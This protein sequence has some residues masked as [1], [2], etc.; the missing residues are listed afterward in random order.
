MMMPIDDPGP[1]ADT[2]RTWALDEDLKRHAMSIPA[3]A[4]AARRVARRYIAG[5]SVEDALDYL[6]T[7]D[8]RG[9]AY[10]VEC[11]GESVRDAETAERETEAFLR[12]IPQVDAAGYSPTISF[13]LSHVGSLVDPGL[14]LGNAMLIAEAADAAGT[15]L[16]ISAEGSDRTDLVLDLFEQLSDVYPATGITLQARL[17]RSSGDLERVLDRPG[18]VR[19]VK[20]AFLEPES[21]AH[22]RGSEALTEAYTDLSESLVRAGHR[23]NFATHDADLVDEL[24]VRLGGELRGEHV[25]FEMLQGLGTELLDGLRADGYATREYAVFGPQWWLYVLNRIAEHPGRVL[26]ALV[27]LS[28]S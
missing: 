14:G 28:T 10:S 23:V 15:H 13:D 9:H 16:M 21:I 6:R 4:Q 7:N 8:A 19:I 1:A 5:E 24:R 26:D 3:V 25:E 18:P 17:H 12:L 27:D 11:M 20:G 22:P 2:L